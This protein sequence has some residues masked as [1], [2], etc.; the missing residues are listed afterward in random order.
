MEQAEQVNRIGLPQMI[1]EYV[2]PCLARNYSPA[3][4]RTVLDAVSTTQDLCKAI[5]KISALVDAGTLLI[6]SC[7]QC[8]SNE[9]ISFVVS[10]IVRKLMNVYGNGV[11]N[12]HLVDLVQKANVAVN[13]ATKNKM[14][15]NMFLCVWFNVLS[16]FII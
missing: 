10:N 4:A 8:E 5:V 11:D 12:C 6:S 1:E 9:P 15:L 13:L 14:V 16:V 2:R 3:S 7:Y